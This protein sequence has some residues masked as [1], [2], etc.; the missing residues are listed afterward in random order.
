M[1]SVALE[2]LLFFTIPVFYSHISVDL[3]FIWP[4]NMFIV[5][6][7]S[8]EL[9]VVFENGPELLPLLV[10]THKIVEIEDSS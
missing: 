1:D 9:R 4:V 10:I 5:E 8:I 2:C 6:E 7:L 3:K